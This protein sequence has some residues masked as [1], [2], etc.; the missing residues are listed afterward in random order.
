MEREINSIRDLIDM[1]L[2]E[3]DGQENFGQIA[4][5]LEYF[6]SDVI[7]DGENRFETVY[8]SLCA[9]GEKD[10]ADKYLK[11]IIEELEA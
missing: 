8:E 1:I 3:V 6:N 2:E 7:I 9:I 11:P 4:N 5:I 10:L